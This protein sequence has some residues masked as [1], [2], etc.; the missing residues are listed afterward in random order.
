MKLV[1]T[2]TVAEG[3][4]F[5]KLTFTGLE[6]TD[7]RYR[8]KAWIELESLSAQRLDA[9]RDLLTENESVRGVK[10]L[11][12]DIE[13]RKKVVSGDDG[14]PTPRSVSQF[15]DFF[16]LLMLKRKRVR[17][18][19]RIAG[20]R[21]LC[22]HVSKA[23]YFPPQQQLDHVIPERTILTLSYKE[24]GQFKEK[25]YT[26]EADDCRAAT[27]EGILER[28]D[29][30]IETDELKAQYDK[31]TARFSKISKK[32]GGSVLGSRNSYS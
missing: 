7:W 12:A 6:E 1:M 23:E 8:K 30:Y 16:V 32:I 11:L 2:K 29:L 20:G 19:K 10:T 9:L 3:I 4:G 27:V 28:A 17:L 25:I 22:Y 13:R 15:C 14:D 31:V 18:Y 26:F 24:F 21:H 5:D